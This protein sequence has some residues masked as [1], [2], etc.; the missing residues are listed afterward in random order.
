M[1]S[2]APSQSVSIIPRDIHF[3]VQSARGHHWLGGDPVGTA[4]FNALSLTFPDGERFFIE[5]V[6]AHRDGLDSTLAQDVRAF[7]AQE[8]LHSR[9]HHLFNEMIDPARYPVEEIEADLRKR[10]DRM[11]KR[12]P[13]MMLLGTIALEHITAMMAEILHANAHLF[14]G[15]SPELDRLWR[16]HAMEE[17]EHKAVAFDVFLH[18]TKGWWPIRRYAR[19][20]IVTIIVGALFVGSVTSYAARLLEA[21]GWSRRD[22]KKAVERYL[23][24]SPGLMRCGWRSFFAWFRPGF[25]P[26]DIDTSHVVEAWRAEFEAKPMA[27]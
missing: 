9:E 26:W 19:R 25:H 5:A 22:A 11:R 8:A 7:I 24:T 1:S 14:E 2:L 23:W 13:K 4:V 16:W 21:E 27:A 20:C 3:D 6:R 10:L 17:N 18:A 12:G 15:V